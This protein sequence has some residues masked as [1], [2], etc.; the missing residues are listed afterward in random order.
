MERC[1]HC[2]KEI[3]KNAKICSNCGC[4]TQSKNGSQKSKKVNKAVVVVGLILAVLGAIC[5]IVVV[6]SLNAF[7]HTERMIMIKYVAPVLAILL[8][9]A[10]LCC[11]CTFLNCGSDDY[12]GNHLS[13]VIGMVISVLSFCVVIIA[14]IIKVAFFTYF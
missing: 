5:T 2:G 12:W 7:N 10:M 1:P 11:S 13:N 3:V 4:L 6:F 9:G 14:V 8:L